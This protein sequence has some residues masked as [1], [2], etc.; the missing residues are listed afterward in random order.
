MK[1]IIGHRYRN[2]RGGVEE[3]GGLTKHDGAWVWTIQGNWYRKSDGRFIVSYGIRARDQQLGIEHK[4]NETATVLDL[5]EE[6]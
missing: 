2:G 5:I 3:V 6:V 1:L 4:P